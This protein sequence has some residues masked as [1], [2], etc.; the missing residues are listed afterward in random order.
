MMTPMRGALVGLVLSAP[1]LFTTREA[2][3]ASLQQV[4]DWGV[5][6]LPSDVSMYAYVP[7]NV[8]DRPPVLVLIHY[9]GGTAPA[10][11]GQARG[12]GVA[13]AADEY[14]FIIVVPSSGRCW[15]IVSDKTRTRN[16]NGD[17]HAIRQMMTELLLAL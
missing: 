12:G 3:A 7:D 15:D 9:C 5:A 1:F 2:R 8:A 10:V 4:G 16:G 11:F 13:Q 6:G 17:S 14:G